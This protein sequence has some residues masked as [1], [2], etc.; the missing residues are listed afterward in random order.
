MKLKT[1]AALAALAL[2]AVGAASA[3][4]T[5]PPPVA[6]APTACTNDAGAAPPF[7]IT[8]KR[9][10]L[11]KQIADW[12]AWH[13][14]R[15]GELQCNQSLLEAKRATLVS[16]FTK[17]QAET[18]AFMGRPENQRT[19]D[20]AKVEGARLQA[21]NNEILARDAA[22]KAEEKALQP[23]VD[24]FLAEKKSYTDKVNELNAKNAPKKDEKKK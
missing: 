11:E 9:K 12:E 6:A 4:T 10:V 13:N 1:T 23:L 15:L 24:A 8:A 18:N 20:A 3:Q 17:V 22:L 16:D 19:G 21:A 14:K 7:D 2:F 5:A